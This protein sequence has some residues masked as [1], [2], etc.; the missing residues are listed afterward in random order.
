VNPLEPGA[1]Y[2]TF[3]AA[4]EWICYLS[5]GWGLPRNCLDFY[6]E[7]KNEVSALK[8]PPQ[9][10]QPKFPDKWKSS[11][12][13]VTQWCGFPV[14]SIAEKK[15]MRDRIRRGHPFSA[16]ERELILK[17]CRDDVIDTAL[18]AKEMLPRLGNLPQV[19]FRAH[20]MRPT[21]KIHRAGIPTDVSTYSRLVQY[22]EP[23]KVRIVSQFKGSALDIFEGI[24]MRYSKV[25]ALVHSLDLE[26]VWPKPKRKRSKSKRQDATSGARK[27]KVF[28][29]EVAAF[30]TMA[31]LRPELA[32]LAE[33]V[34]LIND[35]KTFELVIGSDCRSRYP[36]FPFG[37]VTGRC[38]PSSKR[39]LLSQSSWTRGLIAP[40]PGWAIAY[41]DYAAAEILIAA[42]LSGDQNMLSDY[43]RGDVY[44]NCAIRM[45]LAPAGSTKE[46]IGSLRDVMKVWLLSTLYGA[47]PRSLH[48]ELPGSTL[49]QAEEFVRQNRESYSRYWAWSNLRTEIF[50]YETGVE[51]TAFGWQ[52]HLDV[53][54]RFDGYLFSSARNRSRNFPMQATC[55]EILRWACVLASD[56]GI[57]IHAPLHDAVLIGAP[58]AEI[59]DAVGRMRQHMIAASR[60]VLGVEMRVPVPKI[61]HYP[62]RMREPRGAKTWDRIM[63]LLDEVERSSMNLAN[64]GSI[65]PGA[66]PVAAGPAEDFEAGA[67]V[68][69]ERSQTS[70]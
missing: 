49:E 27:R 28:S 51:A 33:A 68:S 26:S 30:E 54:E 8:P 7:F 36:V 25:E 67:V 43:L 38:T 45:G 53:S 4:A 3:N 19:V 12:L 50:L 11:L 37:A 22:R 13:D 31:A 60:L 42:V 16:Q 46:S 63:R 17:Y 21:A 48:E 66:D 15:A 59:E 35:L 24:G 18:V 47:S 39:F 56:D 29:T 61:I 5:L 57:T 6:I 1:L 23:L 44:T 41:L 69:A 70:T 40:L 20:F 65:S 14:R 10:R 2:I 32:P 64:S 62:D 52:H 58:E 9:F 34:K 55:A